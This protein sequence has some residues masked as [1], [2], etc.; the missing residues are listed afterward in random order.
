[1][2]GL[3]S[4]LL[5]LSN[6]VS[7]QHPP[8]SVDVAFLDAVLRLVRYGKDHVWVLQ[9][10]ARSIHDCHYILDA[11]ALKQWLLKQVENCQSNPEH[12]FIPFQ[13]NQ[14]P[15]PL[16]HIEVEVVGE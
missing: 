5:Y 3:D 11:L 7:F 9:K 16:Q 12:D 2:I 4:I 13:K 14:I 6:D 8:H 15:Q 10:L 1:M